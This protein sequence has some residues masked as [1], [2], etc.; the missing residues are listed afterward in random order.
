MLSLLWLPRAALSAGC[1]PCPPALTSWLLLKRKA[2][3]ARTRE[4]LYGPLSF[5]AQAIA[6]IALLDALFD[7]LVDLNQHGRDKGQQIDPADVDERQVG[8]QE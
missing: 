8:N 1:A 4:I 6:A 7:N 2:K 3:A 5:N